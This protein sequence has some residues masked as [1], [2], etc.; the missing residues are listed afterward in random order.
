MLPEKCPACGSYFFGRIGHD[1]VCL[2]CN[3]VLEDFDEE[4]RTC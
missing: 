2:S 3:V 4:E 1:M